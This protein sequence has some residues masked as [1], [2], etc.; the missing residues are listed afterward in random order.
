YGGCCF[1]HTSADRNAVDDAPVRWLNER[2]SYPG[3]ANQLC[4]T[5]LTSI[6]NLLKYNPV[7]PGFFMNFAGYDYYQNRRTGRA[8][9]Q[10][11][12]NGKPDFNRSGQNSETW[13]HNFVFR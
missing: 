10:K 9:A 1:R 11:R 6:S 5:D 13:Y 8:D 4:C 2:W 3:Q 7:L 12:A